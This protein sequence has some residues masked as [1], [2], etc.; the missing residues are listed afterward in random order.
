MDS[1]E[2]LFRLYALYLSQAPLYRKMTMGSQE[3]QC[4]QY[5]TD[6]SGEALEFARTALGIFQGSPLVPA[7]PPLAH[8]V[9]VRAADNALNAAVANGGLLQFDTID[10][11]SD[12]YA[13]S[14]SPFDHITI[15]AG[16]DGVY[17]A[18]ATSSSSGTQASTIGMGLLVNN[19]VTLSG[20]NKSIGGGGSLN[21]TLDNDAIQ[22]LKLK[23]GFTVGL[24]NNSVSGGTDSFTSTYLTLAWIG[25]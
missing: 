7:P 23:A 5:F 17:T 21:Y 15:P 16:L 14:S 25:A 10:I 24:K 1:T 12:G 8:W 18:L 4:I 20:T 2:Q 9:R 6:S 13:P 22:I 11:D 3:P 19:T